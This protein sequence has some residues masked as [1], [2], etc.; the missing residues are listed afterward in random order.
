MANDESAGCAE[1]PK[2]QDDS[3][4]N[5]YGLWKNRAYYKLQE[6][7]LWKY[8]EGP[9]SEPPTIPTLRPTVAYHGLDDNGHLTTAHVWGNE[10]EYGMAVT[11]AEPWHTGN[12]LALG[13]IYNALPDQSLHLLLGITY[14]KDAWEC[15]HS[16]YQP[17]NSARAAAIKGQIMTYCCMGDMNVAKWLTDMQRLYT[18]LCGVKIEFM[19]DREFAL[20]T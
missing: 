17:Q 11:A 1:L 3:A 19:T 14:T 20:A 9:G 7:G 8:I 18:T 10:E 4:N 16:N 15:L 5:N 2:L 6:W 13:R 12:E